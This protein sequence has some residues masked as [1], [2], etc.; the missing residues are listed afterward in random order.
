MK[1][2]KFVSLLACLMLCLLYVSCSDEAPNQVEDSIMSSSSYTSIYPD[3]SSSSVVNYSSSPI[4]VSSSSII[5]DLSSSS[6]V[7]LSSSSDVALSS[8][9][10]V[11]SSSEIVSSSSVEIPVS[12]PSAPK[13]V[14]LTANSEN[15]TAEVTWDAS[16]LAD[17]YFVYY[18]IDPSD[19][20]MKASYEALTA[21]NYT[22]TD[23]E[24]G[25]PYCVKVKAS[26]VVGESDFSE[27]ACIFY[28]SPV[29][30]E[31]V[32][33]NLKVEY[34]EADD[35]FVLTWTGIDME[36]VS[37]KIYTSSTEN[38]TYKYIATAGPLGIMIDDT[39]ATY[40]YTPAHTGTVKY[41]K[42]TAYTLDGVESGFSNI[43]S[44][45]SPAPPLPDPPK[46]SYSDTI[47]GVVLSM[48]ILK[49]GSFIMGCPDAHDDYCE[50]DEKPLHEVTLD[51]FYIAK[52]EVTRGLWNAVMGSYPNT[53]PN[54]CG[55][56]CPVTSVSWDDAQSF[57]STLNTISGDTYRL[58]TEAE[59]EY[60][61]KNKEY[62]YL[63]YFAGGNTAS[64]VAWTWEN[65][66][67]TEHPVGKKRSFGGLYDMSGNA[68]EMVNDWYGTYGSTD[69]TNPK[70]A[71]S[72]TKKVVRGGSYNDMQ[73]Y[74]R[75]TYR[76]EIGK[77]SSATEMGFRL[78]RS[79]N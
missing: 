23:G 33:R 20:Y 50:Y 61:A 44:A 38:G 28:P 7:V 46:T 58:P 78:A 9:S 40:S 4:I 35:E 25:L 42:V 2:K 68:S 24:P 59:W 16:D 47:N 30:D 39:T 12:V 37:Y 34:S 60:A 53:N 67:N 77:T 65:S 55:D 6:E 27:E 79:V 26:N 57:I 49:N 66:E 11:S 22:V 32:P 76:D 73:D 43:A 52:Y 5:I 69:Q 71:S 36:F 1:K 14:I 63:D 54:T 10:V 41:H 64:T 29:L 51:S 75:V 18:M 72:G 8:S 21:T 13:N 74:A 3:I 19:P 15:G 45:T 70:G 17:N 48:V 31:T 62:E 56:D